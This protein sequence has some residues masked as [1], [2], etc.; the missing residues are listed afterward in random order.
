[1]PSAVRTLIE[2]RAARLP[3]P[4]RSI[5][6]EAAVIGRTFSLRDMLAVKA[7]LGEGGPEAT[8]ELAEVVR[9]AVDAGLVTELPEGSPADYRFAHEHVRSF[10]LSTLNP[11]RRRALHAALVDLLTAGAEVPAESLP[12]LARHA[13]AAGDREGAARFS[14]DAAKAALAASAPEEVLRVVDRALPVVSAPQDRIALLTARDDALGMLRRPAD[15]IEGLAELTALAEA[16]GDTHAEL[17]ASLRRAAA[18]RLTGDDDRALQLAAEVRATSAAHGD[19][20][21]ELTACLELG[22]GYLGK[23]LGESYTPPEQESDLDRA[24]EAFTCACE[25]ARELDDVAALAAATRELGV[26][27]TGRVRSW[28]REYEVTHG[29][30]EVLARVAGGESADGILATMGVAPLY[31]RSVELLERAVALFEEVGDRRGLMSSIIALAYIRF[32]P[33]IHLNASARRLEEIRHLATQLA[34]LSR[35]SERDRAEAQMLYGVHVFARAKVVPDLAVDRGTDAYER[36]Q[37]LGDRSLAFLAAGGV[38]MVHLELADLNAAVGWVDRAAAAANADPTPFK[39]RQLAMW[40]GSCCAA[41]GDRDGMLDHLGQAVELAEQHRRLPARCEALAHLAGEVARLG[42]RIGD[43]ELLE[44]AERHAAATIEAVGS[45]PGHPLW[46]ARAHAALTRVRTARGDPA[47]ALDAARRAVE[48]LLDADLEDLNL[49]IR[50]PATRAILAGGSDEERGY[51]GQM[52][53]IALMLIAQRIVD[54]DV[55]VRWFL[56]PVGHELTEL[57]GPLDH[58][59]APREHPGAGLGEGDARLLRLLVDGRTNRQIAHA[60]GLDDDGL[61][62]RLAEFQARVG[63]GSRAEAAAFAFRERVI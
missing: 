7:Q 37:L 46:G 21:V 3:S 54:E 1:M 18:L 57:A 36:A 5:L 58:G 11:P 13:L 4:T 14:I 60:L 43:E 59:P 34:S 50:V 49:D 6:A 31:A 47:G 35:E 32:A 17:E 38:A 20:R 39:A 40:R 33:D 52:V 45:L 56:G 26:I 53:R 62:R 28:F 15:R 2:R 63:I 24:E 25:L 12:L 22:Q 27:T 19:T 41:A 48:T 8:A 61:T 10:V 23:P 55:R 29:V 16:L 51:A 42:E 9:P 44:L 30:E